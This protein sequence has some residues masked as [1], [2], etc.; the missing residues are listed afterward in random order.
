MPTYRISVVNS[1]FTASEDHELED[2]DSAWRYSMKAAFEIGF[3]L[4]LRGEKFYGCEVSVHEGDE[5]QRRFMVS[6]GV[7]PL[8]QP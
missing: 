1:D 4:L 7:T 2:A 5:L 3:D 6:A 8:Q